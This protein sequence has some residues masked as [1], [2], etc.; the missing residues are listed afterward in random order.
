V[1]GIVF[2][3]QYKTT[4]TDMR[5]PLQDGA[6]AGQL[7]RG[8]DFKSDLCSC[9]D[10]NPTCLHS[11][12]CQ[13]CRA[14]D[15]YQAAGVEQYWTVIGLG[16]LT[17]FIGNA[18][19]V[20]FRLLLYGTV[21]KGLRGMAAMLNCLILGCIFYRYRRKLRTKLGVSEEDQP[22]LFIDIL[23]FG[24]CSCCVVAQEARAF[25]AATGVKV[26]CCCQLTSEA[27][28]PFAGQPQ[29]LMMTGPPVYVQPVNGQVV[30]R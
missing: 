13:W 28:Q 7:N 20:L 22:G 2:A 8:G 30:S 15:T 6:G 12:F 3:Y 27:G 29:S 26:E 18:I 9:F 5:P 24:F 16:V 21:G 23:L 19:T 17:P 25:D 10:D 4:V 14:A 11:L 1:G